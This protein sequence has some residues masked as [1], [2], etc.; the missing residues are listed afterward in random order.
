MKRA[1]IVTAFVILMSALL[2]A[3][4]IW[5]DVNIY[6]AGAGLSV[7]DVVVVNIEDISKLK[8]SMSMNDDSSFTI[9]S[10]PDSSLTA[11][12]PR[13]SSNRDK[14][15]DSQSSFSA[16]GSLRLSVASQI[17]ER[18]DNGKYRIS[19][20]RE[21]V[22]NGIINRFRVRGIIDPAIIKGRNV[23]SNEI[24]DFVLDIRGITERGAVSITRPEIQEGES[25]NASLTEQEKQALIIDYLNEMINELTK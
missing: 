5:R 19:G 13:I 20:L 17:T 21:Y 6:S 2:T 7:G 22:F 23:P 9:V 3:R 15:E 12:L 10:N 1:A 24:A 16:D 8:F 25:A 4:T 14:T 18:L 11:F